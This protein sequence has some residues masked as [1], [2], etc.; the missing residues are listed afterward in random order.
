MVWSL[1]HLCLSLVVPAAFLPAC[2]GSSTPNASR[3]ED[4][5]VLSEQSST[6]VSGKLEKGFAGVGALTV[7]VAGYGY[8]G[9]FC[10]GTLIADQWVLT[11]AHCLMEQA[12]VKITPRMVSF[13][14]GND[15]NPVGYAKPAGSFYQADA[16]Y[17]HES[18]TSSANR[19][20]IAL[21]HLTKKVGPEVSRYAYARESLLFPNANVTYVGYG[22][23]DGLLQAGSG[24]KRSAVIPVSAVYNQTYKS[25]YNG[26]GVCFGDSGG[27][28]LFTRSDGSHVVVGVN[29][30][31]GGAYPGSDP[32]K[33]GG[34][35]T[36]VFYYSGWITNKLTGTQ[37]SCKDDPKICVCA[38]ACQGDGSC[39][40]ALCQ[41]ASCRDV[42]L[43]FQEC[44]PTD[45]DCAMGCYLG[46][47]VQAQEQVDAMGQCMAKHCTPASEGDPVDQDCIQ[48]NCKPQID[49]CFP[50]VTGDKT[51][52][53]VY[54]CMVECPQDDAKCQQGCFDTGTEEAQDSLIGMFDCFDQK[55]KDITDQDKW[56]EC[57]E[58]SCKDKIDACL[59]PKPE[60]PATPANP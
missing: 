8:G 51:C 38:A 46:G 39:Q 41:T 14:I 19:D 30:T 59:P 44:E 50:V 60:T 11:A 37:P 2:T 24:V 18:Y 23:T 32:C 28:G 34:Y 43:C 9:S 15:S 6:I 12:G 55:C 20:D 5:A 56:K 58:T 22:C 1:R 3:G 21:V 45:Q 35:H 42:Y 16:F 52:D 53:Q 13:F 33:T 25:R 10:T 47:T 49:A 7:S 48:K 40:N 29:S 36:A 57:A 27:P 26:S 31:T 4:G 17:V 54:G